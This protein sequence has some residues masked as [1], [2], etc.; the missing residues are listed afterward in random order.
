MKLKP[1]TKKQMRWQIAGEVFTLILT[2]LN[3]WLSKSIALK[4]FGG[5]LILLA[6]NEAVVTFLRWKKFPLVDEKGDE[7]FMEEK[8][9]TLFATVGTILILSTVIFFIIVVIQA[10]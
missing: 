10:F 9:N 6:L 3:I 4:V 8:T 5:I 1:I 7:A 2:G